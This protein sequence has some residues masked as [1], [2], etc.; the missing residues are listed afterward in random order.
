M[1]VCVECIIP[2]LRCSWLEIH[3]TFCVPELTRIHTTYCTDFAAAAKSAIQ[4]E[5]RVHFYFPYIYWKGSSLKKNAAAV[6]ILWWW[7]AEEFLC[8]LSRRTYLFILRCKRVSAC[9]WFQYTTLLWECM[10]PHWVHL[11]VISK[12]CRA[13]TWRSV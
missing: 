8:A 4:I 2:R 6:C 12:Y 13:D 7:M 9:T 5:Y 1:F 10:S 3:P 11:I